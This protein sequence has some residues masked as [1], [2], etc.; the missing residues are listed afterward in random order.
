MRAFALRPVRSRWRR[1]P[2]LYPH[3]CARCSRG[4]SCGRGSRDASGS[5]PGSSGPAAPS[6]GERGFLLVFLAPLLVLLAAFFLGTLE[7]TAASQARVALQ[8]RLDVCAV[9]LAVRREKLFARLTKLN[10]TIDLTVAGITAARAALLVPGAGEA[11]VATEEALLRANEAL[12]RA[13]DAA[14]ALAAAA[15]AVDTSCARSTFSSAPAACVASPPLPGAFERRATPFPDVGGSLR[16]REKGPELSR[17]RCF[18]N[19][20]LTELAVRGDPGLARG[21]FGDEYLR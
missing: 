7:V 20:A 1:S 18:G 8:S 14:V 17:L 3:S 15:E 5:I 12:T 21:G 11:A 10:A 4:P 19:R 13:E 6:R 16:F 2:A 9:K